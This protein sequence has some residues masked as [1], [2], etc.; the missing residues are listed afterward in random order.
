M[1]DKLQ[2]WLFEHSVVEAINIAACKQTIADD[3]LLAIEIQAFVQQAV[4]TAVNQILF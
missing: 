3:L 2:K 1:N 4:S